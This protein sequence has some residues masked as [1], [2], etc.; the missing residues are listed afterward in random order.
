MWY[1]KKPL[2]RY[3]GWF[4]LFKG[5]MMKVIDSLE[6]N[7]KNVMFPRFSNVLCI[8]SEK[9]KKIT[10][11]F[12]IRES[13]VY[14]KGD[15]IYSVEAKEGIWWMRYNQE[16]IVIGI[17]AS[18]ESKPVEKWR[19]QAYPF[20]EK[21]NSPPFSLWIYQGLEIHAKK[22]IIAAGENE[23]EV[24]RQINIPNYRLPI[25]SY[26]KNAYELAKQSLFSLRVYNEKR[27]LM[28][29]YAGLPWFFQFWT[30]DTAISL[31]APGFFKRWEMKHFLSNYPV[32]SDAYRNIAGH[33]GGLRSVDAPLWMAFRKKEWG[34]PFNIKEYENTEF[35]LNEAK[36]TWMDTISRE[37]AR[38]ENQALKAAVLKGTT[39]EKM[40]KEAI[41]SSFLQ[42]NILVD[43]REKDGSIDWTKRPNIFLV[44]YVYQGL[45]SQKEWEYTIDAHIAALWLSWGGFATLDKRH[46]DF[47]SIH[48]G[49][50][51]KSYHQGDSWFWIN[52]IAAIVMNRV[53]KKKYQ[54]YVKKIFKASAEDICKKGIPGHASELSSA[55]VFEPAGV[56]SQLWSAATFIEL[57][58]ELNKTS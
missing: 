28:G 8:E 6:G 10:I 7:I 5:R 15:R 53:N 16:N 39:R 40:F 55:S 19:E 47:Y 54:K 45:L 31:K 50:D 57:H 41:R 21:R 9:E 44:A 42:N 13:Y 11:N 35:I 24:L 36:E 18:G 58:R 4:L 46:P 26:S 23:N 48:T 22:I 52:N 2:S 1:T 25:T 49:E 38:I 34:M 32:F 20:D 27:E 17:K 51:P 14:P 33:T 30:R 37:G 56:P 43:G 29:L 3:Q 12:D